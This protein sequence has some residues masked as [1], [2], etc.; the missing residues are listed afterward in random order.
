[1]RHVVLLV[2]PFQWHCYAAL[3]EGYVTSCGCSEDAEQRLLRFRI[4]CTKPPVRCAQNIALREQGVPACISVYQA[5]RFIDQKDAR[6]ET[7]QGIGKRRGVHL[8]KIDY[9]TDQD[10]SPQV[11]GEELTRQSR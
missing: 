5:P 10:R 4:D 3:S 9:L 2:S 8:A 6:S 7:I 11:E 1:M